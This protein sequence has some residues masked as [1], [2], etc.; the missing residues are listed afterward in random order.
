M[1]QLEDRL[2]HIRVTY[3]EIESILERIHQLDAEYNNLLPELPK[4][5]QPTDT[6]LDR[7]DKFAVELEN[8]NAVIY[9][10]KLC[11]IRKAQ[12]ILEIQDLKKTFLKESRNTVPNLKRRYM[13]IRIIS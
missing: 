12:E 4:R 3:S 10:Q 1:S 6:Q 8:F 9:P 7:L 13:T 2:N 5:Y 11:L